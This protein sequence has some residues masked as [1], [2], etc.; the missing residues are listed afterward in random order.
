MTPY[1]VYVYESH[2]NV[3]L[4]VITRE[5]D[6]QKNHILAHSFPL[7]TILTIWRGWASYSCQRNLWGDQMLGGKVW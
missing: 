7:L 4:L 5:G 1:G 2:S 3:F 6:G